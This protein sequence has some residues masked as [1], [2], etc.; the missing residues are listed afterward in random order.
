MAVFAGLFET[1]DDERTQVIEGLLRFGAKQELAEKK[2]RG[3]SRKCQGNQP[4]TRQVRKPTTSSTNTTSKI[5]SAR[6]LLAECISGSSSKSPGPAKSPLKADPEQ[7]IPRLVRRSKPH[8]RRR[9]ARMHRA[10]RHACRGM[11]A[12]TTEPCPMIDRTVLRH[13][14][15]HGMGNWVRLGLLRRALHRWVHRGL[16]NG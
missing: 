5:S 11:C 16:G 10:F 12:K 3:M 15:I 13:N 6:T 14:R 4:S 7:H 8:L 2:R 9:S 1:L